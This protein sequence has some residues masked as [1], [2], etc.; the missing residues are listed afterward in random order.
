M[1]ASDKD[2]K[3]IFVNFA[4]RRKDDTLSFGGG[5]K[6]MT[7]VFF[8]VLAGLVVL[9][10]LLWPELLLSYFYGPTLILIA[11]LAAV[12][13]RKILIKIQV[14]RFARK[15]QAARAKAERKETD[16]RVLH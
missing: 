1:A 6:F 12:A 15:M 8:S 9:I 16:G 2:D 14:A 10:A 7:G 4:T 13:A 3:I 11:V 5:P